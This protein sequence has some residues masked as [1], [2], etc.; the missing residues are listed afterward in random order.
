MHTSQLYASEVQLLSAC[1]EPDI[2]FQTLGSPE[3]SWTRQKVEQLRK[4]EGG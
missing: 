2:R 4:D 3:Q 1:F